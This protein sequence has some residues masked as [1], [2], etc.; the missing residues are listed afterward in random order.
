MGEWK[1]QPHLRLID[2]KLIDISIDKIKRLIISLPPRH[3]KSKLVSEFFPAWY[4]GSYPNKVIRLISHDKTF[5]TTWSRKALQHFNES[6][7]LFNIYHQTPLS[8]AKETESLWEIES[9]GGL[10][11]SIGVLGTILGKGADVLI[12]DDPSTPQEMHSATQRDKLWDWYRETIYPRLEP[13]G[14]IIIVMARL[15][16]DDLVSRVLTYTQH[17]NWEYIRMPAFAEINDILGRAENEPLWKERFDT[18]ELNKIRLTQGPFI[19]SSQYQQNPLTSESVIFKKEY[20]KYYESPSDSKLKI[21]VWD[22]AFKEKQTNDFSV[23]LT[24]ILT[25]NNN[26]EVLDMYRSK[27]SFFELENQ[28]RY[29]SGLYLP[30]KILIEDAGSGTSLLQRLKAITNLPVLEEKTM[31]KVTRAHEASPLCETQ[32]IYLPSGATWL[33]TF[34]NEMSNFPNGE[35][36]DIVDAFCIGV[37]YLKKFI[38]KTNGK[39]HNIKMRPEKIRNIISGF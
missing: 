35:H 29:L 23:C 19:W 20:W 3:G 24:M 4:L 11:E 30:N 21:Q 8:I 1:I 9:Y 25:Q 38:T 33:P 13:N 34:I 28:T 7:E 22:T 37:N 2:D 10:M 6:K 26:I 27:P 31:H 32:K 18:E 12:I 16:E 5:A 39:I 15:H 14:T 36:D 17:D